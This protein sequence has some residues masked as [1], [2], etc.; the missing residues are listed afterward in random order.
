MDGHVLRLIVPSHIYRDFL[1]GV[2]I[3][4][5]TYSKLE[6]FVHRIVGL[7]YVCLLYCAVLVGPLASLLFLGTVPHHVAF[8]TAPHADHRLRAVRYLVTLL[9]QNRYET[10][11]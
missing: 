9:R 10:L 4:A 2:K 1:I 6:K 7:G 11:R 8:T 5:R 3:Y